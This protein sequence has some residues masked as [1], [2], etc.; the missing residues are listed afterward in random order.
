MHL[1]AEEVLQK[2]VPRL[3]QPET[4]LSVDLR[5]VHSVIAA[6]AGLGGDQVQASHKLDGESERPG[7]LADVG[8]EAAEDAANFPVFVSLEDGALGTQVGHPGR[9]DEDRFAGA[10]CP[11]D[12]A[13]EFVP[14]IDC[15]R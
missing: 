3:P 9:L 2:R 7:N 1:R 13:L 5:S 12:D 8:T 4:A 15:D 14:V 10:A 11:V 6:V